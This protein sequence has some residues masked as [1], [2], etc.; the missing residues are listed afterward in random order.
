[1]SVVSRSARRRWSLVLAGVTALCLVPVVIAALPTADASGDLT[2]LRAK[3]L[4]SGSQPHQ[5]YAESQGGVDLPALPEL[6]QVGSLLGGN[7]RIRTWYDSPQAWR[8]ALVDPLGERDI[9]REG[10]GTYVW[11]FERNLVTNI[12]GEI[13]TRLPWVADVT[14]PDL[15]RRLLT[16]AAPGDRVTPIPSRRVAGVDAAGLR[17][18]P[19]DPA[20]TIGHVD[21]WADPASGLPVRVELSGRTGRPVFTTRFLELKQTR[22]AASVLIPS[23]PPSA[24]FVTTELGTDLT[25]PWLGPAALPGTLAGRARTRNPDGISGVGAYGRGWSTLV[26]LR[27]PGRVGSRTLAAARNGGGVE[28]TLPGGEGV[29]IGTSLLSAIIVRSP[30]DRVTRRTYL[31]AGFVNPTLLRQAGAEM[32]ANPVSVG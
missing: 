30:G 29:E 5:G 11:D 27:L 26:V 3:M 6:D 21:L 31:V 20:T 8:V 17:I 22:P 12:V 32:L 2:R 19:S 9:Y 16:S 14:P 7:T 15:A 13:G 28:A 25:I 18:T 4:A 1:V 23:L 10:L 24:G